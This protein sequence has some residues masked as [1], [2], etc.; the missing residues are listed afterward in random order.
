[1]PGRASRWISNGK[2]ARTEL[3]VGTFA[4]LKQA[5][6]RDRKRKETRRLILSR[7]TSRIEPASTSRRSCVTSDRRRESRLPF[8]RSPGRNSEQDSWIRR[9]RF[10]CWSIGLMAAS[11]AMHMQY[12]Q[13]WL[14]RWA[15]KLD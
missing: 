15:G 5:R 7:R 10:S 8:G 11:L 14:R 12:E 6:L 9:E 2:N 13:P 1:M 3:D 4:A